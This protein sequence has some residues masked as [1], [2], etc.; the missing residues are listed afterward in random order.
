MLGTGVHTYILRGKPNASSPQ[1]R[2]ERMPI[3]ANDGLA[4][5][6][7]FAH[8]VADTHRAC[9]RCLVSSLW[10]SSHLSL[11][12]LRPIRNLL[13]NR[14]W[15]GFQE[16]SFQIVERAAFSSRGD[17]LLQGNSYLKS[18]LRLLLQRRV[19][20]QICYLKSPPSENPPFDFP[21]LHS[22]RT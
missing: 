2:P 21:N 19:W 1:Q 16:G 20:G 22:N 13:G 7:A 17:L 5:Y 4:T 14:E 9:A 6:A 10:I 11:P 3:S 18:T 15:G 8:G 12:L